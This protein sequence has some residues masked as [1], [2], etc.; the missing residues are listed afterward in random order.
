MDVTTPNHTVYLYPGG[1][2][3]MEQLNQQGVYI[4]QV[5]S[6]KPHGQ[7]QLSFCRRFAFV[8]GHSLF[9]ISSEYLIKLCRKYVSKVFYL[10]HRKQSDG[11]QEQV[12]LLIS[13]LSPLV[14]ITDLFKPMTD[15]LTLLFILSRVDRLCMII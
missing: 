2:I 14:Y 1:N 10:F 4:H 8:L 7:G 11:L 13:K 6:F 9:I 3:L 5:V 15:P 12:L